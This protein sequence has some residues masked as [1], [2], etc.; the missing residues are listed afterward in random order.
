[1]HSVEDIERLEQILASLED[2]DHTSISPETTSAI[3]EPDTPTEGETPLEGLYR[4]LSDLDIDLHKLLESDLDKRQRR[5][6]FS[7]GRYPKE[8]LH[9]DG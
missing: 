5:E 9:K 3:V 8:G 7:T 6:D 4:K 1:M 2:L